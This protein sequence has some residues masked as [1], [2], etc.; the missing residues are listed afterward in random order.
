MTNVLI[1]LPSY[2]HP[3]CLLKTFD[4]TIFYHV[5]EEFFIKH[6][7]TN[8]RYIREAQF[9]SRSLGQIIFIQYKK[10]SINL[11]DIYTE[12]ST[13]HP[14]ETDIVTEPARVVIFFMNLFLW[15]KKLVMVL[16]SIEVDYWWTWIC[17]ALYGIPRRASLN[18]LINK[19]SEKD[20]VR[21][22]SCQ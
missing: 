5:G 17:L 10:N 16:R 4:I 20:H 8:S 9:F 18:I 3:E 12:N 11:F 7:Y 15:I 2:N 14:W 13:V 19:T 21:R 6:T 22:S 1:C